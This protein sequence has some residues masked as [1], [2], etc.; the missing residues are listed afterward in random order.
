M[1]ILIV[2]QYFTPEPGATS[3]RLESFAK[4]MADR[5]HD[6]TVICEFPN[7][8]AGKLQP[9][10]KWRLFRWEKRDN[11]KILR[12]AV[13]TF[14]KKNN[15]KRMMF[16]LSFAF[17]SFIA[18]LLIR[19]ADV[20]FTSSPPIFHAY[21]AMLAARIKGSHF[22]LDIRDLWPDSALEI[23]AVSNKFFLKLGSYIERQIYNHAGLIFTVS[24]GIKDKIEQRGGQNKTHVVYNGSFEKILNWSGDNTQVRSQPGWSDKTV[25]LYAGLMGLGQGL[26]DLI[27]EIQSMPN[28][29]LSFIFIGEGVEKNLLD[30]K[31]KELKIENMRLVDS[32]PLD[33]VIPYMY[34]ADFLFVIL[35][36]KELFKSA[37]PSK[38]FD[39]MAIGKPILTNVD[40]ELREIMEQHN[41]GLY[42]SLQEPGSLKRAIEILTS[43]PDKRREMGENGRKLVAARF[44]R[45]KITADAVKL[46]EDQ[47]KF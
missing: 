1:R 37:I 21:T 30:D 14:K 27:P 19:R 24:K 8:P 6:V 33:D 39:C 25:V 45:S 3:N 31:V 40:G 35:R 10:D 2:T 17:T 42:F 22:V 36:D 34:A 18:A 15:I 29:N 44:L 47:L 5:G 7:H 38:F 12:T 28:N 20:I 46:I 13:F 4:G 32:M 9:G 26:T 16:Y 23:E 11:Y 43:S 41:T